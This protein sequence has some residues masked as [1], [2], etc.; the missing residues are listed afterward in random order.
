MTDIRAEVPEL[1]ILALSIRN[2]KIFIMNMFK[3]YI[4]RK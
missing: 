1:Q 3:K 4:Q 2:I